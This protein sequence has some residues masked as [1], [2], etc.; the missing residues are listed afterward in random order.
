MFQTSLGNN[1]SQLVTVSIRRLTST[2]SCYN[3]LQVSCGS[4]APLYLSVRADAC[5]ELVLCLCLTM[6]EIAY[7]GKDVIELEHMII[8]QRPMSEP[9]GRKKGSLFTILLQALDTPS[10]SCSAHLKHNQVLPFK[11]FERRGINTRDQRRSSCRH[12][13]G[14]ATPSSPV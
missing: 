10:P 12:A 9:L 5:P 14:K 4:A 6:Y 2:Q 11:L 3:Y 13:N 8:L 1:L 7:T